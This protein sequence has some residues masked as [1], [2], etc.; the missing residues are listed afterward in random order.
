MAGPVAARSA[1]PP[2]GSTEA[3]GP[4][5]WLA[6]SA[7]VEGSRNRSGKLHA[8]VPERS[9]WLAATWSPAIVGAALPR[10]GGG[11]APASG[12][13]RGVA[14]RRPDCRGAPPSGPLRGVE[15]ERSAPRAVAR[16][17]REALSLK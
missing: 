16:A 13:G 8:T 14:P 6:H 5:Q 10:G 1:G 9:R 7:A 11:L 12:A 2:D 17:H 3:P 15:P 4:G